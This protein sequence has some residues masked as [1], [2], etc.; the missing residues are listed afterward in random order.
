MIRKIVIDNFKCIKEM[1]LDCSGLNLL[2]GTNSSGKSTI[3]QALLFLSQNIS[4]TVGLNGRFVSLGEFE[5]N[6]CRYSSEKAIRVAAFAEQQNG[7][8]K[9]LLR[10]PED[11]RL[12][13]E[14]LLSEGP[15]VGTDLEEMLDGRFRKFQYLSCHRIGP[16]L[17]YRKN[18]S[19]EDTIDSNGVYAISYLN[20][21]SDD[22]LHVNLCKDYN[23]FT[24]L[25]QVNWWLKYIVDAEI[26]TEE[27]PGVDVIKASY[28]TK[29]IAG[30]RPIN[31]GSG[32]SYLVSLLIM[33][34][35]APEEGI[36]VL[37]NPEIHLHPSAQARVCEFLY[38][39]AQSGRQLFVE[40]HSDHIFNGFR[41]GL[42]NG[43]M[44]KEIVNIQ[45]AYLNDENVTEAMQVEIGRYG[46][47]R[48]QRKNLF[49]QFDIDMNR[50]INI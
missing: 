25:N 2:I 35:S 15:A 43:S 8:G 24:L 46:N 3:L 23:D 39:I 11:D 14:T 18:M 19:L 12:Q 32:I 9:T 44:D 29:E 45:F 36:I 21:H 38:F 10:I 34:L 31:I 20:S 13:V 40:T 16:E 1:E 42:S 48:N 4:E 41:V 49:D 30:V 28:T 26:S 17:S 37:E 50:M 47:I 33:C 5:E 6:R 27:I 22:P 7:I